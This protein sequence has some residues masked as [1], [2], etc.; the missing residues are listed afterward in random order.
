[1]KNDKLHLISR[2]ISKILT[3]IFMVIILTFSMVESASFYKLFILFLKELIFIIIFYA[4]TY[5]IIYTALCIFNDRKTYTVKT[6]AERIGYDSRQ[7]QLGAGKISIYEYKYNDKKYN[8]CM[9]GDSS[10]LKIKINPNNPNDI[11]FANA[12]GRQMMCITGVLTFILLFFTIL[13]KRL[14]L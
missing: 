8:V 1:M 2:R 4:L 9:I 5:F 13:F 10:S 3:F 6:K 7:N 11:I 14:F 12:T